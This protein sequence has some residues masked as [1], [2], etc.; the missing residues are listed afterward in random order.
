MPLLHAA[1]TLL[2]LL[3]LFLISIIGIRMLSYWKSFLFASHRYRVRDAVSTNDLRGL[4]VPFVK[5]QVTT[6]GSAGSSEVIMRGVRNLVLLADEAPEFYGAFLS[7][8]VV[9]ESQEQVELLLERFAGCSIPVSGLLLPPDYA[10]PQGTQLKARGLHYAVQ[11]R[12]EGWNAKPGR[13]FIVHYDEESVLVPEEM[14]KL[15]AQLSKTDKKVLEG[16]IYYPLE[17]RDAAALCRSM[18]ANRPVGCFECR[19]VMEKGVPLHLHGS[20][21]VVEEAFENELG[22]DIGCLD[23]QPL[24][25]EDYVFGMSA[26]TRAGS[27]VFGWHGVVMLEQPPFSVKSAFKQRHRWI[28]GVLQEMEMNRRLPAFQGLSWA[29]R[30][31]IAWGTRYRIATFALGAVAGSLSM[32]LLPYAAL[33]NVQALRDGQELPLPWG[34]DLWLSLVGV[35]WLGSVL[36]GAWC[37]VAYAGLHRAERVAEVARAVLLAPVAGLIECS[38][39]LWAVTEW[40]MGRR[41]VFWQPTPKTKAADRDAVWAAAAASAVLSPSTH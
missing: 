32:L 6:R 22:W 16:P 35:L 2:G 36:I 40:A 31:R 33:T 29:T 26:F 25:A 1:W 30:Q 15:I 17:Y 24:I 18:E 5:V 38:A 14:R 34:V 37:N 41:D 27:E 21:L 11:R 9:T 20:N 39:G 23:G 7:V 28:F 12:R 8:E 10:T 3:L 19:Q 4:N 13:T